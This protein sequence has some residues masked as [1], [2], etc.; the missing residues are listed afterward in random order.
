MG[1]LAIVVFSDLV[2][3]TALLA[4]LGDDRMERVRRAHV[5]DVTG[6]V[7]AAGGRVVKT[8]G[9]GAM[10]SFES[11]LGALRA[12][13]GI[14]ASVER[15][16]AAQGGLGLAARVGVAAGEPISHD[17]DLHGMTVVIA[18]RL[19]SAAAGGEVLV[20]DLVHALVASRDGVVLDEARDYELKGVPMPVRASR[21][22]WRE[23]ELEAHGERATES[24]VTAVPEAAAIDDRSHPD[25]STPVPASDEPALASGS[26]HAPGGSA[27]PPEGVPLPRVLAAYEAEPLIGRD[28]EIGMLR[29]ATA[30]RDGC[31]AV[32]VLGEPGIGKTRHAAAAAADAHARGEVVVLARCPPEAVIP[33]EPWVRA[34]GE[35]ARAGDEGWREALARAAGVELSGLVPELGVHATAAPERAIAGEVVAAEG[36]RYRLLRGIGAALA[37]GAGNAPLHV[38][39]DDAHWCDAASAQALGHMLDGAPTAQLVLTVTARER[40]LGRGHPV[41]RVLGDLRR[42]GDLS[43]LRLTGLDAGGMAALVAA[44]VGRAITPR[45]A[46]RLQTRTAGNPFFAAELARDLD[47]RDAL[48]DGE[49][50]EAAPVPDAVTDLVE[51][52]LAR[53]DPVT[54]RLLV[55]VAAIGPSAPVALAARV[56]GIGEEDAERAVSQ[57]LSER[58]V[59]DV[60]AALPTIAFPHA[61]IRE[62]LTAGANDAARA[63]LHLAV[64]RALEEEDPGVEPA[65]LARHYGLAVAVAGPEPAIAAY[66]AAAATAAEGHDHEQAAAHMRGALALL[67]ESDQTARAAVLLELGEQELL[68]ADLTRARQAFREAGDAA[69]ATGDAGTLARAALGFAGGD[70][71][72]GWETGNDDTAT[73]VLLREGLDALG[74]TEPRLAL[75][76][77]YRLAYA[78]TYTDDGDV[79]DALARH[80]E[81][82]DRRLGDTESRVIARSTRLIAI[83]TFGSGPLA[84]LDQYEEILDLADLAEGCGRE[85]LLFRG[86]HWLS[87]ACYALGRIAEC[88][89]A[90]ERAAEIAGRLGSP[91]FTWEVDVSRGHRLLD[92]GDRKGSEALIRRA[93]TTVRRL[94]PDIHITVELMTLLSTIWIYDG[95]TAT[96]RPVYAAMQAVGPSGIMSA[97]MAWAAAIDG[98]HDTARRGLASLLDGDDLAALRRPDIQLPTALCFLALTATLAGDRVAGARLRPL[99]EPLRPYLMQAAPALFFGHIAEWHIGRLELL[100]GRPEAAVEELRAAVARADVLDLVWLTAWA[101]VDLALALHRRNSPGAAEQARATLAEG[102]A[103]AERY[104]MRWVIDRAALARAELDGREPPT[105]ILAATTERAR[106]IRALTARGGRRAL[107]ARVRGLDDEALER[108]FAEPRRQRALLRAMARGLQPAHAGGFSGLI[109]Y[110]LEPFAIESPPDAPWRWAIEVDSR[111]GRARLLEP[112][113]LEAAVTIHFGLAEWVRVTAGVQDAITAM[114]AGRCSVEGDVLLA[115]RLEAMFAGR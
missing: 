2:D 114:V 95:E 85:D 5:D 109:A 39:L 87:V 59:D 91:R 40:E 103:I 13:A 47:E 76:M 7:A 33:F 30:P 31:R 94:R 60:P 49:A 9:D 89:R 78:L 4:R 26:A 53:L 16:D 27:R 73:V 80:A 12:A 62:A 102:E 71:A 104:A 38:V 67:G 112:A 24:A 90:I 64:A 99:L 22:R 77:I 42:T 93:G 35:L 43:E 36:A 3:S 25:R 55:A 92:R 101:R 106:P 74:D 113:P 11:G 66:R 56:A 70:I 84:V 41:S 19:C 45:L 96:A 83:C 110:E 32:L 44:R 50:L 82:L 107:A 54:E 21:L 69:R 68:A 88:E 37:H 65:E 57:A 18:S 48:R 98:D 29:E 79:L 20:Q 111:A 6:V 115:A 63:R 46:A 72:F 34:I 100:A 97:I 75:R 10:A 81:E 15:L 51:E 23:L 61:L 28:R 14:Q 17:D 1:G 86:I 105:P 58:L 108:R 52:R 8:L